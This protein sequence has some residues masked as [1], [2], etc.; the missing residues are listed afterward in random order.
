MY[1]HLLENCPETIHQIY[2]Q[3]TSGV[4]DWM[5]EYH[6]TVPFLGGS[7]LMLQPQSA[8]LVK[9]AALDV[10]INQ[11]KN[12]EIT[13]LLQLMD[14]HRP[15]KVI[16]ALSANDW[17]RSGQEIQ[18]LY[19]KLLNQVRGLVESDQ[20]CIIQGVAGL[21]GRTTRSMRGP[22]ED[23]SVTNQTVLKIHL[24]VSEAAKSERCTYVDMTSIHPTAA[25][26]VHYQDQSAQKAFEL[27]RPYL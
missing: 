7:R 4:A 26:G 22:G 18:E 9:R 8:F 20:D 27:I 11:Q 5:A 15:E 14:R 10:P 23:I 6:S 19:R 17:R 1:Q 25:D 3:G 16:V 21:D 24:A 13:S 2:A 12:F